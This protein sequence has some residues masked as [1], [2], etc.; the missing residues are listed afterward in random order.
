MYVSSF[1]FST[2]QTGEMF[3]QNVTDIESVTFI[4]EQSEDSQE[5]LMCG[6]QHSDKDFQCINYL[7]EGIS[8]NLR[9]RQ[10][11]SENSSP[12]SSST[13]LTN[14]EQEKLLWVS[15]QIQTT[16]ILCEVI[17]LLLF[18]N[19]KRVIYFCCCCSKYLEVFAVQFLTKA[20]CN[21][22]HDLRVRSIYM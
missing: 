10:G 21:M 19:L 4:I 12:N 15:K 5:C 7:E 14:Q 3:L 11:S 17:F 20:F 22:V 1:F 18:L 16:I 6:Y 13:D 9:L 8:K 2:W